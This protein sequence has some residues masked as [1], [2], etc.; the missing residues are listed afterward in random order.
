MIG[1]DQLVSG[2]RCR[3]A[4]VGDELD[5]IRREEGD[6]DQVCNATLADILAR[7]DRLHRRAG[8]DLLEPRTARGD[9]PDQGRVDCGRRVFEYELRLD[10]AAA[11]CKGTADGKRVRIYLVGIVRL[12]QLEPARR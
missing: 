4:T 5:D 7:G 8:L 6:I 9:S 3:L 12:I 10:P 11:H 2:Q 1:A